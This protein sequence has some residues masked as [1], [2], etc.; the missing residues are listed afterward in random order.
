MDGRRDV[1]LHCTDTGGFEKLQCDL[2]NCWC[3]VES[4]GGSLLTLCSLESSGEAVST[5]V[6]EILVHLLPCYP[7]EAILEVRPAM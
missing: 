3:V 6:P 5:V 4:S 2:G 1:S 7:Y